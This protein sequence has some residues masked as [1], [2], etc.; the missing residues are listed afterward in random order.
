MTEPTPTTATSG[1]AGRPK[2][3]FLGRLLLLFSAL[4]FI[5]AAQEGCYQNAQRIRG[6]VVEK[7]YN[8]GTSAVGRAGTGSKSV[9]WVRYR[10]TTPEGEVRQTLTRSCRGR[11]LKEGGP[12]D[13]GTCSEAG[14][15]PGRRLEKSFVHDLHGNRYGLA[16]GRHPRLRAARRDARG[17]C[18]PFL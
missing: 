8:R 1:T 18:C 3:R 12:V 11:E 17:D 16:G 4:F 14:R 5:L 9:H 7:G 13:I 15:Q 10:F 2:R 6:T